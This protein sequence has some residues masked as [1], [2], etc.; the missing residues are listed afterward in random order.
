MGPLTLSDLARRILRSSGNLTLVLDN[1]EKRALVKRRQQGEDKRFIMATITPAGR[2]LI[3]GIFPQHARQITEIMSRLT[4]E[5]QRQLGA[6][7]KK[8]G[9]GEQEESR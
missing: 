6:L 2:K 3:A 9:K 4:P 7:C 8:L 5:E 1:L